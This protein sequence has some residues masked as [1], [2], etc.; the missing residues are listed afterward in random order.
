[1][2]NDNF[3][4]TTRRG[5]Q[6]N[7]IVHSER[8]PLNGARRDDVLIS[9][10]DAAMLGLANGDP[11]V[12]R[13]SV[14][15]MRGRCMIAPITPGNVEVHWPEG[16]VLIQRGVRDEECGIPDFNATVEVIPAR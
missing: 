15:E 9:K 8:D 6:F 2:G 10:A 13:S 1:L 16:N 14:G 5:K 11:V 12:V 3:R 4:L 7:T